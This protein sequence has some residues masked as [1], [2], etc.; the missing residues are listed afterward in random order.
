MK[1]IFKMN[2]K[3]FT[4]GFLI[5][6]LVFPL[7]QKSVFTYI[8]LVFG[9]GVHRSTFFFK[10]APVKVLEFVFLKTKIATY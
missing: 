5:F 6:F 7:L 9:L 4:D 3:T 1:I 10:K 8:F 2:A